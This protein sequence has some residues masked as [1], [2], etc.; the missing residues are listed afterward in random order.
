VALN[1]HHDNESSMIG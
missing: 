1:V